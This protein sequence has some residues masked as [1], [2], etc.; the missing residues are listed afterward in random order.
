METFQNGLVRV[1]ILILFA[2]TV[3]SS[4]N[5]SDINTSM[6]PLNFLG[7]KNAEDLTLTIYY[8]SLT[9][10][11]PFSLDADELVNWADTHRIVISGSQLQHHIALLNQLSNTTVV[12]VGTETFLDARI[13]YLFETMQEGKIFEVAMWGDNHNL[14]VNG[15]EVEENDIFYDIIIP[16]LPKEV[17]VALVD[18]KN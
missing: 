9:A 1:T 15:V 17:V 12:P 3:L 4:C 18:R 10:L 8:K 5:R 7:H 2:V 16:F 6:P 14:F 11:T 13:Y